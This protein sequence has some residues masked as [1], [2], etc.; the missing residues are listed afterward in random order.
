MKNLIIIGVGGFAREVYWHA[1]NSHGFNVDWQIKGF[2]DGDMKLSDEDYKKLPEN[3]PV[4][5]D[6]DN[7]KICPDDVFTCAIG[8]PQV[9]KKLVEKILQRGGEFINLISTDSYVVP[10]A[11]L[12]RGII[13]A[14][15]T[16][17]N[18]LSEID[19]FVVIN[20]LSGTGHDTKVGKFTC[21]MSGVNVTGGTIIGEKVFIG[22]NVVFAP[23]AKIGDGAFVG[24]GSVIL[25]K[26]RAGAKVF[27]NPAMEI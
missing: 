11:K 21:I 5:G 26:V 22:S 2:L 27:G 16:V 18:D 23:K 13:L 7:Y 19:D 9:R 12:G 20:S 10:S 14:Q 15:K 17:V 4:L 25:K 3:V 1:Q 6:V 24:A 8:T